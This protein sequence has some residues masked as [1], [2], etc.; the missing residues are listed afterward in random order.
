MLRYLGLLAIVATQPALAAKGAAEKP[1]APSTIVIA[2]EQC[3]LSDATT[4]TSQTGSKFFGAVAALIVPMLVKAGIDAA[5][6][7]LGKVR[8]Q[9]ASGETRGFLW[10]RTGG[11]RNLTLNMPSCVT[12]VTGAFQGSYADSEVRAGAKNETLLAPNAPV[13][14]IRKRIDRHI[15]LRPEDAS[16]PIYSVLE[17][18]LTDADV[19]AFRF[20]PV[21]LRV[22]ELMPGNGAKEQGLVYTI[23]ITGPGA[24]PDGTVYAAAPISFGTVAAGFEVTAIGTAADGS[25]APNPKLQPKL[26]KLRTGYLAIPGLSETARAAY[27]ISLRRSYAEDSEYMPYALKVDVV[28]T[29]KPS[30]AARFVAKV[31]GGIKDGVAAKVGEQLAPGKGFADDQALLAAQAAVNDAE[32]ALA[33]AQAEAIPVPAKIEAARIRLTIAI[34]ALQNLRD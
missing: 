10:S 13:D 1:P 27:S 23:S 6:D 14:E 21:Y 31:L 3:V 28:Q 19:T 29:Q 20:E 8:T 5:V 2:H 18:R 11:S 17:A 32:A 7:E 16:A 34:N 15:G 33:A 22:F 12:M 9:K 4:V 24:T 25:L 26:D 30:D